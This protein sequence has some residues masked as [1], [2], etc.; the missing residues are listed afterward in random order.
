MN[1]QQSVGIAQLSI[2]PQKQV[3]STRRL[4]ALAIAKRVFQLAAQAGHPFEG[5]TPPVWAKKWLASEEF[6]LT[7]VET[8]QVAIPIFAR[9]KDVVRAYMHAS[10]DSQEPIIADVNK[11]HVGGNDTTGFIP[12]VIVVDGKHRHQAATLKAEP[13]IKAWIGVKALP[14]IESMRAQA[15]QPSSRMRSKLESAAI[16]AN[17]SKNSHPHDCNC[18]ACSSRKMA[19]GKNVHAADPSDVTPHSDPSDRYDKPIGRSLDPSDTGEDANSNDKRTPVSKG[20]SNSEL[21]QM[22]FTNAR[23]VKAGPIKLKRL[24][25]KYKKDVAAGWKPP[26]QGKAAPGFEGTV[27]HMKKHPEIDNP[28]ALSYWMKDKGYHSHK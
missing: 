8:G 7:E 16:L 19:A 26:I 25:V 27:K 3:Q 5:I 17:T 22:Q 15:I 14:K 4:T 23:N 6:V 28:Y 9:R 24:I 1:I 20:A 2:T 18:S 12:E 13:R 21:Q 11:N 10:A